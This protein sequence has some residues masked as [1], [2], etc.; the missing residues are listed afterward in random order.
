MEEQV[1]N[2]KPMKGFAIA[3]IIIGCLAFLLSLMSFFG[4]IFA[5][6]GALGLWPAIIALIL[7]IIGLIMA[8]KANASKGLAIAVIIISLI[9]GG[10]S[11]YGIYKAKKAVEDFAGDLDSWSEEMNDALEELE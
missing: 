7:G 8:G 5:G 3:G 1:Q 10:L 4:S 9:A 2:P 6:M 11:Y